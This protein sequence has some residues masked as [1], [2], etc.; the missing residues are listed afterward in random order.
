MRSI[1]AREQP[2]GAAVGTRTDP[3][4]RD[5]PRTPRGGCRSSSR[6]LPCGSGAR[7]YPWHV[8]G[9]GMQGSVPATPLR[10]LLLLQL[11]VH[12][13]SCRRKEGGSR[14]G[15]GHTDVPDKGGGRGEGL[16]VVTTSPQGPELSSPRCPTCRAELGTAVLSPK[17]GRGHSS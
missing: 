17:R 5:P 13:N 14:R 10:L 9:E 3:G 16:P 15:R 6:E 11:R 8:A 1:R 12:G 4:V 2:D 7:F